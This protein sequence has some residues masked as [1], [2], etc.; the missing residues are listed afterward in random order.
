M[1][2]FLN[3]FYI[4]ILIVCL[5]L[6]MIQPAN[7]WSLGTVKCNGSSAYNWSAHTGDTCTI[8]NADYPMNIGVLM[9]DYYTGS[10]CHWVGAQK[11]YECPDKHCNTSFALPYSYG[12]RYFVI[13]SPYRGISYARKQFWNADFP[14]PLPEWDFEA[15]VTQGSAPLAVSF[16][17]TTEDYPFYN[18]WSFGDGTWANATTLSNPYTHKKVAHTYTKNGTYTV[19][20]I[21]NVS[22]I[23]RQGSVTKTAYINVSEP[24]VVNFTA[25]TTSGPTLLAIQFNDTS[26][27]TPTSWTW[28][29]GDG[30][31]STE[32]NPSHIY[33]EAGTFNVSL[34][35]AN[36]GG[37]DTEE[38]AG[39]V[40][41]TEPAH[42]GY[43]SCNDFNNLT[44]YYTC[45]ACNDNAYCDGLCINSACDI[46]GTDVTFGIDNYTCSGGWQKASCGQNAFLNWALTGDSNPFE[47]SLSIARWRKTIDCPVIGHSYAFDN[48]AGK[49]VY[50]ARIKNMD[51]DLYP[52]NSFNHEVAVELPAGQ[53]KSVFDSWRFFNYGNLNIIKGDQQMPV[54][55]NQCNTEIVIKTITRVYGCLEYEPAD[56]EQFY[57]D[58]NGN[59]VSS[60]LG[61]CPSSVTVKSLNAAYSQK[62]YSDLPD[63]L[64]PIVE[65]I[66]NSHEFG[67]S[68]WD[69]DSIN[70]SM[71]IF[72]YNIRDEQMIDSLNGKTVDGYSIQI[73]HDIEFERTRDD[74]RKQLSK[75]RENPDYQINGISMGTNAFGITNSPEY[76][77]EVWVNELTPENRKLDNTIIDGW[78]IQVIRLS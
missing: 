9:Y 27:G 47:D 16:N 49:D 78:T 8:T 76:Y 32:Q 77:A 62:K 12:R 17:D 25:N 55:G 68:R 29:F 73:V 75:F 28:S 2:L 51:I 19:T 34:T 72:I 45:V 33:A 71:I 44:D 46:S 14:L 59:I 30:T 57:V 37:S 21:A 50:F 63:E 10:N 67:I 7:A 56:V 69:V 64:K 5:I 41:V 35:A 23:G 54:G 65:S 58:S 48:P 42:C 15:N 52:N 74:V 22:Y 31:N 1:P 70:K 36:A 66:K 3:T 4:P 43:N 24:L 60:Q 13:Y 40:V 11:V 39:Y 26:A 18:R 53:N 61:S 6:I 20:M 38:K